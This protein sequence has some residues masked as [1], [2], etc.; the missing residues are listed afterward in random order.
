MLDLPMGRNGFQPALA[1]VYSTGTGDGEFGLGWQLKVPSIIRKTAKGVPRYS[2]TDVF[3]LGGDELVRMPSAIAGEIEYRPRIERA[4]SRITH[5]VDR[6][7][8]DYWEVRERNGTT[9]VFGAASDPNAVVHDPRDGSRRFSWLLSDVTDSSGNRIRYDYEKDAVRS[10]GLRQWDR[11]YMSSVRYA[12]HGDPAAPGYVVQVRFVYEP[13]PHGVSVHTPGFELRTLRRCKRIEIW[14]ETDARRRQKSYHLT[15]ADEDPAQPLPVNGAS[16]LS[17][18]R[19]EGHA[20]DGV[21]A[22]DRSESTPTLQFRYGEFEPHR[23]RL[24]RVGGSRLPMDPLGADGLEM[25]DLSGDGLPDIV[26]VRNQTRF[27]RNL[28]NGGFAAPEVAPHAPAGIHLGDPAIQLID[29]QGD[30]YPDL[31]VASAG[32]IA[33]FYELGGDGPWD[34]RRFQPY[35]VAPAVDFGDADVRLLDIDGDGVTDAVRTGATLEC[36]L[37]RSE[38][39]E[40]AYVA[41]ESLETFPNVRFSDARVRVADMD[42]DGLSDVVL[43][44][45]G[46]VD[47]WSSQG[48]GRFAPRVTMR[49]SPVLPPSH[50]VRR[51]L[52]ADVDGDGAADLLYVGEGFVRLWVNMSGTAWSPPV[53]I[54][55]TPRTANVDDIRIADLLGVGIPGIL[56]TE[57]A[58]GLEREPR[59]FF[60]DLALG[61]KPYLLERMAN[62]AGAVTRVEYVP[63]TRFYL[64]DRR[65]GTPWL[66]RLP[67]PV[68]VVARV[69]SVDLIARGKV[70]TEY[71]YHHGRWDGLERRFAGFAR[72]DQLDTQIF[73]DFHLDCPGLTAARYDEV[74]PTRFSPPTETRTW[75]FSADLA[76]EPPAE[77]P[78]RE[79]WWGDPQALGPSTFEGREIATLPMPA[80]AV[81]ARA[82]NGCVVRTELFARDSS[83][84]EQRP[85][86]VTET[87][88]DVL[89]VARGIGDDPVLLPQP[90][91]E[92]TTQWDR[93]SDPLTT[94]DFV[95]DVGPNGMPRLQLT[96]GVPRGRD[97]RV[98][99]PAAS[100]PFLATFTRTAYAQ[101]TNPNVHILD[102]VA[103][104]TTYEIVDDDRAARTDSYPAAGDFWASVLAGIVPRV[105]V[106]AQSLHHYDGPAFDGLD[107]GLVGANGWLTRSEDLVMTDAAVAAAYAGMSAAPIPPFLQIGRAIPWTAE[108]P[109][110]FRAAVEATANPCPRGVAVPGGYIYHAGDAIRARGYFQLTTSQEFGPRGLVIGEMDSLGNRMSVEFNDGYELRATRVVDPAGL[111][112][113]VT[114]DKRLLRP[115]TITDA[116]ANVTAYRYTPLGFVA[117]VALLGKD[118]GSEGDAP[119]QP[120]TVYRYALDEFERNGLPAYMEIIQRVYHANDLSVSAAVR[121]KELRSREYSDGFGR[122]IQRREEAEA[123]VYGADAFVDSVLSVASNETLVA[124]HADSVAQPNVVVKEWNIHDNKGRVV[125]QFESFRSRGWQ[126][127]W[128]TAAQLRSSVR[129][130]YDGRGRIT[131]VRNEDGSEEIIVYGTPGQ[132]DAPNAH[133]PSP[134]ISFSYD[135]NDNAVR[136]PAAPSAVAVPAAH[137]DTPSSVRV[138]ALGRAVERILRVGPAPADELRTRTEYD[139]RGSTIRVLDPMNRVASEWRRDLLGRA[140]F[141]RHIDRGDQWTVFN[142]EGDVIEQR[143]GR[144]AMLLETTDELRRPIRRWARDSA[145]APTSLRQLTVYGDSPDSPLDPFTAAAANCLAK[146]LL[147]FDESGTLLTDSYDFAGNVLQQT[148]SILELR[149]I[150]DHFN[151]ALAAGAAIT[152]YVVDWTP[153]AGRAFEDHVLQLLSGSEFTI[154]T[155]YDALGRPRTVDYP[156]DATG[157]RKTLEISYDNRGAVNHV[158]FDGRVFVGR[159]GRNARGQRVLAVL[160]D[161]AAAD[162]SPGVLLRYAYDPLT[163]RLARLQAHKYAVASATS[164]RT[165]GAA[166][167]DF[168]YAHDLVGNVVTLWDRGPLAGLAANPSLQRT[169]LYDPAYRLKFADGRESSDAP[170]G[171]PWTTQVRGSDPAATHGYTESFEY[172]DAGNLTKLT[173]T[174]ASSTN[175][176]ASIRRFDLVAGSNRLVAIRTG[177]RTVPY[178][179]DASGNMTAESPERRMDWNYRHQMTLFQSGVAGSVPDVVTQ[180]CHD[181]T[182][183]RLLSFTWR[184]D[185]STNEVAYIGGVHERHLETG[186]AG[187]TEMSVAHVMDDAGRVATVQAGDLTAETGPAIRFYLP[188][189]LGSS[190]LVIGRDPDVRNDESW[191]PFG[192]TLFGGFDRKRFSFTGKERDVTGYYQF[193]ARAYAPWAARWL[194]VDPLAVTGLG[195]SYAYCANNPYKFVDPTGLYEVAKDTPENRRIQSEVGEMIVDLFNDR[196]TR[197]DVLGEKLDMIAWFSKTEHQVYV[198]E[199]G[200][201]LNVRLRPFG[202]DTKAWNFLVPKPPPKNPKYEGHTYCTAVSFSFALLA[203]EKINRETG[204]FDF[205]TIKGKDRYKNLL[206][207]QQL[208]YR[209]VDSLGAPEAMGFAGLGYRVSNLRTDL[210]PGA[211]VNYYTN[212]KPKSEP[213]GHSFVFLGYNETFQWRLFL[214]HPFE[215]SKWYERSGVLGV[216]IRELVPGKTVSFTF[217]ELRQKGAVGANWLPTQRQVE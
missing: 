154:S 131:T 12:D 217:D 90:V 71:R 179:Y 91:A 62:G 41:R 139:I 9:S 159:I 57:G 151:I 36:H 98:A 21:A 11:S 19:L 147:R 17:S 175:P 75:F 46:R 199:I 110:D 42:G 215:P 113:E 85:Y 28:G 53:T 211:M 117:S 181:F 76:P 111:T 34:V 2:E 103:S 49:N 125:R 176:A 92:R 185:E 69:E 86:T 120:S 74:D 128:P 45:D 43:I 193:G 10:D 134:W 145:A 61:R 25:V 214:D 20:D 39:W 78:S 202:D 183:T 171:R 83:S 26:E 200:A 82:L 48:R 65:I 8:G 170:P 167:M 35:D 157:V 93:G 213:R 115:A 63:S 150:R 122:T 73:E 207:F 1:L 188:D 106:V 112:M 123:E 27:W 148:R 3:T 72:V 47:Y 192:E 54:R 66:T 33:G 182:G 158:A 160:G 152:P 138:D 126:F 143:D 141:N 196:S 4:R 23:A 88:W 51:V 184:S 195:N 24:V 14:T 187:T 156:A 64:E 114:H 99:A 140:L 101:P 37:N 209:S 190:A 22:A 89:T 67:F 32:R 30:G 95:G 44:T 163:A 132:L 79:F 29:A 177:T 84:L 15:Y 174:P 189:H 52:L 105:R 146:P 180:Y 59:Y 162:T 94:L 208:W 129:L 116:N 165:S 144:G 87:A 169:F 96:I 56:W 100:E 68:H 149:L 203:I 7:R 191:S 153:A 81:A 107:L 18:V 102:R 212:S 161:D 136:T 80:R 205:G 133:A 168:E 119:D 6:A 77:D 210:H 155:L 173:H 13:R 206:R 108:Y 40:S 127:E 142:A 198:D 135:R 178:A 109:L 5:V 16:L 197:A 97:Y 194:S 38:R 137:I 130:T 31:L 216:E 164:L 121:T 104:A 55:G 118:D 201:G 172:D 70:V 58:G 204:H 60:L 50:D 166:V 124:W 186:A